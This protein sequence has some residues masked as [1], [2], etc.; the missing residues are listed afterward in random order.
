VTSESTQLIEDPQT[1]RE[2]SLA[3]AEVKKAALS[4]HDSVDLIK[5]VVMELS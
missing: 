3:Y 4:R 5:Q 2:Y 1:V